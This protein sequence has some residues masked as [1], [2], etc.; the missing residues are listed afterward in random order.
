MRDKESLLTFPDPKRDDDETLAKRRVAFIFSH[1]ALR[2]GW[3]NPNIFQIC[4]LNETKFRNAQA[5]GNRARRAV[6][7][8]PKRRPRSGR[9]GEH[10]DGRSEPELTTRMCREYQ[11][12][13]ESGDYRE[14]VR[15]RFGG[16]WSGLT[17][18]EREWAESYQVRNF[19]VGSAARP[20][21]KTRRGRIRLHIRAGQGRDGGIQPGV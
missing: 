13:V 16:D 7:G 19:A 3:D 12:E 2:E 5:A 18:E 1:S 17:P 20:T 10:S 11:S 8:E 14:M 21:G 15:E 6:G 4:A 9:V